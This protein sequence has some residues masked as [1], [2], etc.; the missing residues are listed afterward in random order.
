MNLM[1][2]MF[3][4]LRKALDEC[5]QPLEKVSRLR[6][7]L[8]R[9]LRSAWEIATAKAGRVAVNIA[10]IITI[11]IDNSLKGGVIPS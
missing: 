5:K 10:F 9:V 8:N 1:N 4:W 6:M 7:M 3:V 2:G 11:G